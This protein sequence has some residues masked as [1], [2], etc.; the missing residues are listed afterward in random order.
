M[1]KRTAALAPVAPS[2]VSLLLGG[3]IGR[4]VVTGPAGG[5]RI[6]RPWPGAPAANAAIGPIKYRTVS[7]QRSP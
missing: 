4:K 7:F 6:E 1:A 3:L 5:R 2:N